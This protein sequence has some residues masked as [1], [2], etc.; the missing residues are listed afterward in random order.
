MCTVKSVINSGNFVAIDCGNGRCGIRTSREKDGT[1]GSYVKN[2]SVKYVMKLLR[3]KYRK[4]IRK[5]NFI[6]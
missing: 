4:D 6:N 1:F 5:K 2:S 3:D